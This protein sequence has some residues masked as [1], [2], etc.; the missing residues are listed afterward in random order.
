MMQHRGQNLISMP[1]PVY[2]CAQH[3]HSDT[4]VHVACETE[5]L[6]LNVPVQ[7]M[8]IRDAIREDRCC[9][10]QSARSGV[11]ACGEGGSSCRSAAFCS[12]V[13]DQ[14]PPHNRHDDSD[15]RRGL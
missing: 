11:G 4:S 14:K 12:A 9:Q 5:L 15:L 8:E 10:V 7:V 1:G 13:I 6:L 2:I 3:L